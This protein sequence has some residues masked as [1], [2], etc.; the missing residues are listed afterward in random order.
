MNILKTA[1]KG[2]LLA[3]LAALVALLPP[4]QPAA[5]ALEVAGQTVPDTAEVA[6]KQL[7]LNGAGKRVKV[8][9]D[10]YVAA[11]YTTAKT[12][13][14]AAIITP[15][16][17]APR[18][19]E[20]RMLRTV[21]AP[22]MFESFTEGMEAN[23][24]NGKAGMKQYATQI[25]ALSKIFDDAKSAAKGDAIQIDFIPAQGTLITIRGKPHLAIP[26]DDFAAAM[27]SIWLGKSPAQ[28]NLKQKLLGG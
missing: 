13:D 7:L 2:A 26:G 19:I 14:P 5:R 16:P 25:A 6:G 21:G 11:L 8:I 10:V 4:A 28:E 12:V 17:P 27:L 9:F 24:P 3:A 18:R 15:T 23:I 1:Q 20:L 22:T